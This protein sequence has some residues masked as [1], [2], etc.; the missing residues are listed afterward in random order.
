MSRAPVL[1]TLLVALLIA[2]AS[3]AR[4][5][6]GPV[7]WRR[8][9]DQPAEWYASPAAAVLADT[10]LLYQFSDGGWPK[11]RDMSL[12]PDAEAAARGKPV[13]A[14]ERMPTIDNDA[15]HI[16]LVFLGRVITAGQDRE[17][18][19]AAVNRGLDYLFAAQY[20]N[21]GWPQFFPLR[22]GYYT[23]ITFND[24]AMAGV[25]GVLQAVAQGRAP[26]AFV[27]PA[28]RARAA[29]AVARGVD[30]ILRCQVVIDGKKTVWC[31][32]HDEHTFA[33][34][35]ARKFEPAT[36][37]GAESVGIVRFLLTVEP[38]AEVVDAVESAAA[39]FEQV[40]ITGLRY[41]RVPAPD[42]P[43]GHDNVVVS[44]PA[45]PPLWARFYEI[46]TNRPVFTGRDAVIHYALNEI[47]PERRSGYAWYVTTPEKLLAKEIP[48]W[49]KTLKEFTVTN[50]ERDLRPQFPR[51]RRA[52]GLL[53]GEVAVV[54]N[55][56]Y[57]PGLQLD[58]YRPVTPGPRPG[59]LIIHAGG[60][61]SGTREME[62]VFA[63]RLAAHGYVAVPVDYR[64]GPAGC[65]PAALHDL[66]A[67]VRWLRAHA[68]DHG[69]DPARIAA[70]G[71]SAGGTLATLLGTTNGLA[72]F[73]GEVGE[74]AGSSAVQAVVD[75][76]GLV[77][78]TAPELVAQQDAT[79]SAPTRFLGGSFA[80][81][82]AAWRAAS[83]LT[84]AGPASAP[85]F[86]IN[87]TATTPI[88]PGRAAMRDK[89]R[90]AGVASDLV[91]IPDTPH[92]FWLFEPWAT[93]TVEAT[94]RFL[95]RQF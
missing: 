36:L 82:S 62:R 75:I 69:V 24:G 15:T 67:A 65:F 89:L 76:D 94:V 63:Q 17:A 32:Q 22:E 85:V 84:H 95:S 73:E 33:P 54:E 26:F 6:E 27:D 92:P 83:A 77:D 10:V 49:R 43:R 53:P 61:D 55:I 38:T 70:V 8:A 64:L 4:A 60:W 79:P 9:L 58:V 74:R 93:P 51:I 50:A 78:F 48:A 29:E 87:S 19:R 42:L 45:A 25:L 46:G 86:F 57:A 52:Q 13:P 7:T 39:W 3:A 80:K 30:C 56:T 20:P 11:N 37:S 68:A 47:E 5:A 44:D 91:T 34:A 16:Q 12:A 35:P 81:N 2:A 23:H 18:Y 66:K 14:D 31:A 1:F 88:L 28:R 41:E 71:M 59:V 40:K 72:E 21:G 90:V